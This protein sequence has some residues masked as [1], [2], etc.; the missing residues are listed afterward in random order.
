MIDDGWREIANTALAGVWPS[1]VPARLTACSSPASLRSCSHR[2]NAQA[3]GARGASPGGPSGIHTVDLRR[4]DLDFGI[5]PVDLPAEIGAACACPRTRQSG[6][7]RTGACGA[8]RPDDTAARAVE[9]RSPYPVQVGDHLDPAPL[10]IAAVG[11][12][13]SSPP[14]N[15]ADRS[16]P[17]RT[18]SPTPSCSRCS[19]RHSATSPDTPTPRPRPSSSRYSR[20]HQPDR[21]R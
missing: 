5:D 11:R 12:W 8:R 9:S 17:T 10:P 20:C 7:A 1:A 2:C 6:P 3:A 18:T 21:Q 16:R 14:S 15:S 4:A 13:A 19:A